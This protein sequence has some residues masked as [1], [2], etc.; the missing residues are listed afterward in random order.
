MRGAE[1]GQRVMFSYVDLERRIP[2][3]HPLRAIQAL[4]EPVLR[5][6][7]PRFATRAASSAGAGSAEAPRR[8]DD[9]DLHSV[10]NR[11]DSGRSP[12]D[13]L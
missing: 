7:S 5:E 6:L 3:D 12:A 9:E 2:T 10:L 4:I 13:Q 1:P 11:V 8:G